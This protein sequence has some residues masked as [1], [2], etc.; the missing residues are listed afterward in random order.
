MTKENLLFGIIGVLFGLIIGFVVANSLNRDTSPAAATVSDQPSNSNLPPNHPPFGQ[1]QNAVQPQIAEAIEKA[2]E[3]P[4]DFEAQ[5]TAGD[6]YYQVQR[7]EDAAEFF[8]IANK[9]RPNE[10]EPI[11][12]L[13]N[14]YFDV[15]KFSQAEKWYEL[16]LK[17]KPNDLGVRTDY[18]L[19]FFLRE[20]PDVDRAI[21]EFQISLGMQP[22]HEFTLQNLAV[23]FKE[24]GDTENFRKT[25]D[26]L[27][28]V[29]PNNP[30]LKD[31]SGDK[32]NIQ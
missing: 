21:K 30:L 5:M 19:T 4:A 24:K 18:G 8:E 12:K 29:N 28:K 26:A 10:T 7:F 13:G 20:P 16:A 14:S 15:E 17:N 9:L 25:L 1:S 6:L 31:N 32:V 27:R 23:A 11:V 22:N 3:N 2:R